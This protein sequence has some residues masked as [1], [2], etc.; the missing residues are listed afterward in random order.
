LHN[1]AG[2]A[3]YGALGG[4]AHAVNDLARPLDLGSGLIPQS[5]K[6]RRSGGSPHLDDGHAVL[7]QSTG[8]IRADVG[9]RPERLDRVEVSNESVTPGHQ[10][11]T[12]SE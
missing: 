8:L 7:G 10:R 11:R 6:E 3:F 5:V 2:D 4:P 9:G 1:P 12:A